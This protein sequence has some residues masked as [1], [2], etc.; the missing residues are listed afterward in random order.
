[1][2]M[3]ID[4]DFFI[5][6]EKM[7]MLNQ[8]T[9]DHVCCDKCNSGMMVKLYWKYLNGGNGQVSRSD[10]LSW[11]GMTDDEKGALYL[12]SLVASGLAELVEGGKYRFDM[13]DNQAYLY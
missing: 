3:S 4:M 7:K 5:K 10:V 13:S 6:S 9:K 11:L 2:G 12:D 1:M 8:K